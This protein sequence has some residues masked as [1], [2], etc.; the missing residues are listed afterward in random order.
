[1]GTS[2]LEILRAL[3]SHRS[4][5]VGATDIAEV[6]GVTRQAVDRRLRNIQDDGLVEKYD[7][8]S[9]ATVWY[10]TPAG[11]RYLDDIGPD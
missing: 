9:R 1:M 2:D 3:Q 11:K 8:G 4:P 7:A 6:V 5:A 10:L